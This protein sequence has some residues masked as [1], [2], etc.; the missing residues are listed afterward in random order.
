[1]PFEG[2]STTKIINAVKGYSGDPL[3]L[4]GGTGER[5]VDLVVR[6][7]GTTSSS[8]PTGWVLSKTNTGLYRLS[9]NIGTTDYLVWGDTLVNVAFRVNN[10]EANLL[11]YEVRSSSG[12]LI[13]SE[14]HLGIWVP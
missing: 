14:I 1:M 4:L 2:W 6:E 5:L 9:H 8:L 13:D 7:D 3:A 12:T 11:D 10:Q